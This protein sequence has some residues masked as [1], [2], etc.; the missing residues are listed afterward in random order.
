MDF[1]FTLLRTFVVVS[2]AEGFTRA[3]EQL[4]VTQSAVSHQIRRLEEQVGRPLMHRTTRRITLTEDGEDFLRHSREV[5]SL[6]DRMVRRFQPSP[7]SG[8]VRFGLPENFMGERLPLLLCQFARAFP[9]VRLDVKVSTYPDLRS[10]LDAGELDLA[11]VLSTP[12]SVGDDTVLRR[13]RFVWAASETFGIRDGSSIPL[14]LSPA[15]CVSRKIGV[16]A[17]EKTSIATHIVFTSPNHEG[18]RAAVQAGLAVT[19]LLHD[20]LEPGMKVVDGQFGLPTLAKAEF[21]LI[22][23]HG[24]KSL[25]AREFGKLVMNMPAPLA[26]LAR[27]RPRFTTV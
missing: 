18:L 22:W 19:V 2:E 8:V 20:E 17:L 21:T 26:K 12:H 25:A 13:T 10:M 14:A 24:A 1:D 4:H 7:V 5:L 23:S 6:L 11:V 27:R 9:E 15:P 3:A 16:D